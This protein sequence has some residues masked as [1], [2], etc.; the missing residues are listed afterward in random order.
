MRQSDSSLFKTTLRVTFSM[1]EKDIYRQNWGWQ[2]GGGVSK[3]KTGSLRMDL[4]SFVFIDCLTL[5]ESLND[6]QFCF[7][8]IFSKVFFVFCNL[9]KII[10]FSCC[11]NVLF[12]KQSIKKTQLKFIVYQ[13]YLL[14]SKEPLKLCLCLNKFHMQI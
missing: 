2:W 8:Q 14:F 5:K 13:T 1:F 4:L 6:V 7:S 11:D 3:V 10:L 12:I 9:I